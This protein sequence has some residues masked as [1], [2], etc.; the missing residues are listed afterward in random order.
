M[1]KYFLIICLIAGSYFTAAAQKPDTAG[2]TKKTHRDSLVSTMRDSVKA[3]A[4]VPKTK[5]KKEKVYHPD[6]LHSP[7]TAIIRSLIIPGWG[8]VY[9]HQWWKVPLIYGGLGFLGYL[10]VTN[11]HY[12]NQ[13]LAI[14]K[15]VEHGVTPT[16]RDKYY[17]EYTQYVS[18][19]S[20]ALY[21]ATDA[22]RRDRDLCILGILGA[23]GINV[24]DAYIDAKFIHSYSMD[25]NLS[26]KVKPGLINQPFFAQNISGSY[27]PGI[28][29]T[30]V[31]R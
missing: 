8:Q 2:I 4:F 19:G 9:N 29:V 31:L 11:A 20:T 10:E 24:I 1:T 28:K 13:F 26:I 21:D 30:F 27:V 22:Y 15:Y 18:A 3:R 16:A 7:H 17:V 23:W 14:S 6:S 12:Y 25:N 5:P